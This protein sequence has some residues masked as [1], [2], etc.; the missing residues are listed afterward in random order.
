MSLPF[1]PFEQTFAKTVKFFIEKGS[2]VDIFRKFVQKGHF[3]QQK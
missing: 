1:L 2:N 3:K